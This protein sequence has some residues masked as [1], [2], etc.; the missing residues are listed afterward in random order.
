MKSPCLFLRESVPEIKGK[1]VTSIQSSRCASFSTTSKDGIIIPASPSDKRNLGEMENMSH[2]V[3]SKERYAQTYGMTPVQ[4]EQT[5]RARRQFSEDVHRQILALDSRDESDGNTIGKMKH[6]LICK[7]RYTHRRNPFVC[8]KCW[9]HLPICVCDLFDRDKIALPQGVQGVYIWTHHDEWGKSSNTGSML[10]LALDKTRMLMKGLPD[11]DT[12]LRNEVLDSST[13]SAVP[14]VLWPGKGGRDKQTVSISELRNEELVLVSMEGTWNNCRRMVNKLPD[15]ILRLDLGQEVSDFFSDPSRDNMLL[16]QS[17]HS[18]KAPLP[19][20]I[21][22]SP[23][24]LAPLR[25]QGKGKEGSPTNISTLEATVIALMGLG[26][27]KEDGAWILGNA[28]EKVDR[29]RRFTG[30]IYT[31]N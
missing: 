20:P 12:K 1:L 26:M 15:N 9:T 13:S 4:L 3:S 14:V 18:K 23:S 7:H 16:T 24:L 22:L 30:K 11:H 19:K 27:K 25:R 21:S 6:Q 17:N 10:P 31:R 28:M 5:I 2:L 29:I 8:V